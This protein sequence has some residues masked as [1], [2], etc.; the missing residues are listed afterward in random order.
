MIIFKKIS[1]LN[2]LERVEVM[3]SLNHILSSLFFIIMCI[4]VLK[5]LIEVFI[6]EKKEHITLSAIALLLIILNNI[7][8]TNITFYLTVSNVIL[9]LVIIYFINTIL[10]KYKN[11]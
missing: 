4:Y 7:Y 10:S 9:I 11:H 3:L 1:F 2:I 6:D 8:K 5:K